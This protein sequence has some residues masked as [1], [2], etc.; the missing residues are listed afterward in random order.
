MPVKT[1]LEQL[2]EVQAAITKVMDGQ[3]VAID[4]KRHTL[5]DLAA[6][7]RRE[8]RLL[9]RYNRQLKRGSRYNIGLKRRA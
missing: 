9:S 8:I 1:I 4:G 2:E 7:E 6:L 3:D 5:A